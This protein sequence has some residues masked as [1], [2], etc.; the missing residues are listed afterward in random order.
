MKWFTR[1]VLTEHEIKIGSSRHILKRIAKAIVEKSNTEE[2]FLKHFLGK[3]KRLIHFHI[4]NAC[5]V[6]QKLF[7]EIFLKKGVVAPCFIRSKSE[8]KKITMQ[9]H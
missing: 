8:F 7:L 2:A 1:I 4:P 6:I 5:C 9:L 3:R